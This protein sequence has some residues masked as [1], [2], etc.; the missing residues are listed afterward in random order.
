MS[1]HGA[2][3]ELMGKMKPDSIGFEAKALYE[4]LLAEWDATRSRPVSEKPE[5]DMHVIAVTRTGG[6]RRWRAIGALRVAW[7]DMC[8]CD[9]I[10]YWF[11]DPGAPDEKGASDGK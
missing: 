7:A 8:K 2:L 3:R 11:Y 6:V 1:A 10:A 9:D 4:G 5:G